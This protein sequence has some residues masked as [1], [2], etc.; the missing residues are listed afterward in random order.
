MSYSR[1]PDVLLLKCSIA[2]SMSHSGKPLNNQMSNMFYIC[3]WCWWLLSNVRDR[4]L[5]IDVFQLRDIHPTLLTSWRPDNATTIVM[6]QHIF[7]RVP[8]TALSHPVHHTKI[9][10]Q[11]LAWMCCTKLQKNPALKILPISFHTIHTVQ[12]QFTWNATYLD[13]NIW[14]GIIFK[15][16]VITQTEGMIR[17]L[18]GNHWQIIIKKK[19]K[20]GSMANLHKW[21]SKSRSWRW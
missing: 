14:P 8:F 16:F 7:T 9:W 3:I 20:S 4:L 2:A 17:A 19:Q 21:Q 15:V 12:S 13:F 1:S 18:L 5:H 10:W 11:Q 6:C